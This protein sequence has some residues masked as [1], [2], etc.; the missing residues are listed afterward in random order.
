[1]YYYVKIAH[2]HRNHKIFKSYLKPYLLKRENIYVFHLRKCDTNN[3]KKQSMN[4][5]TIENYTWH[6]A[7]YRSELMKLVEIKIIVTSII[8]LMNPCRKNNPFHVQN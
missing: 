6:N 7:I 3:K 5:F 1:M 4:R 2:L 8:H